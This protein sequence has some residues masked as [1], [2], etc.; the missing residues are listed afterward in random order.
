MIATSDIMTYGC[1]CP[2]EFQGKSSCSCVPAGNALSDIRHGICPV[3]FPYVPGFDVA[4][5]VVKL[6]EGVG[7]VQVRFDQGADPPLVP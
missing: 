6:G 1:T 7:N 2:F 4:G 5:T 3:T